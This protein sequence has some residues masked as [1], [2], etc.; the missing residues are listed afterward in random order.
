[1]GTPKRKL[2]SLSKRPLRNGRGG[3]SYEVKRGKGRELKTT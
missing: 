2:F 1:M 3:I